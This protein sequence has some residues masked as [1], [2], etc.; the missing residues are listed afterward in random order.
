MAHGKREHDVKPLL[1]GALS[2]M[3]GVG[4]PRL[5]VAGDFEGVIDIEETDDE[6][7]AEGALREDIETFLSAKWL[8]LALRT[9]LT[10]LFDKRR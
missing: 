4:F 5:A 6:S 9:P 1:I 10:E 7:V 3:I 8:Q 2:A